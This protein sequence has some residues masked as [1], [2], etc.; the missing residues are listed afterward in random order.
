MESICTVSQDLTKIISVGK[1]NDV[2]WK[3]KTKTSGFN[4]F[5]FS[6][7]PPFRRFWAKLVARGGRIGF[8]LFGTYG[9]NGL[10][11][12]NRRKGGS[13]EH[14]VGSKSIHHYSGTAEVALLLR[15]LLC[16]LAR[17]LVIWQVL[18]WQGYFISLKTFLAESRRMWTRF[19]LLI[20]GI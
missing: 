18:F 13:L 19:V 3:K 10:C 12:W 9:I 20:N 7:M 5:F 2:S 8:E 17:G 1:M 11:S 4:I 15:L 14:I 16:L 6:S